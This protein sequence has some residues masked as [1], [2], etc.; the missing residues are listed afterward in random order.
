[1]AIAS[2]PAFLVHS[3][4]GDQLV[5]FCPE[6]TF[7]LPVCGR[8]FPFINWW[9]QTDNTVHCRNL[10]TAE[11]FATQPFD[12]ISRYG[13][14]CEPLG[15]DNSESCIFQLVGTCVQNKMF[16]PRT[17]THTKNGWKI[18]RFNDTPIGRKIS[19]HTTSWTSSGY[20]A[21]RLRPLARRAFKTARPL[22]VA[23]RA[24][25]PWVRLRRTTEGW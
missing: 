6:N 7:Y 23:T 9:R 19:V 17:G 14:M 8:I 4:R 20:T 2:L 21:K 16:R 24:R 25:K 10:Y 18:I 15:N 13:P 12:C 1:M 22:L 3:R 5:Q 11:C